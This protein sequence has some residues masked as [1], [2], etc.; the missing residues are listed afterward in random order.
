MHFQLQVQ[1]E[2]RAR[3]PL[4]LPRLP[5]HR[6]R[7]RPRQICLQNYRR[8]FHQTY[9][10][11]ALR[12]FLH[13][14]LANLIDDDRRHGAA[15]LHLQFHA[16]LVLQPDGQHPYDVYADEEG[17]PDYR[18]YFVHQFLFQLSPPVGADDFL[19]YKRYRQANAV[20]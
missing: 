18:Q 9:Q 12:V 15:V 1:Q 16:C 7:H 5:Q 20:L 10:Q 6:F 8:I 2:P 4:D 17:D 19:S 3:H 11:L 13:H 14:E